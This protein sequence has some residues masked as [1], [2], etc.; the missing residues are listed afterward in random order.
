VR[1]EGELEPPAVAIEEHPEIAAAPVEVVARAEDVLHELLR[2][3]G[4]HELHQAAS[5]LRRDREAIELRLRL[6]HGLHERVLEVVA[7]RGRANERI[8][9]GRADPNVAR[10]AARHAQHAEPVDVEA[11]TELREVLA[12]L[13]VASAGRGRGIQAILLAFHGG[14]ERSSATP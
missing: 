1:G 3:G 6:D 8:V 10:T 5:T 13:V 2:R 12:L 4:R 7:L 11:T 14:L 9:F